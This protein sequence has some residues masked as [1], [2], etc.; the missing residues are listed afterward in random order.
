MKKVKRLK[1][2]YNLYFP[3]D[4]IAWIKQN[5]AADERKPSEFMT[6]LIRK[7]AKPK[8]ECQP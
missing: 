8:K 2:G 4:V 6:L 1:K 5:A 7:L 3:P